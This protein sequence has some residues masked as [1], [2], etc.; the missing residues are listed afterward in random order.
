[1]DRTTVDPVEELLTEPRVYAG[2]ATKEV[3]RWVPGVDPVTG[4]KI[5]VVEHEIYLWS[6]QF[7][8]FILHD[9]LQHKKRARK[10]SER[11]GQL[12]MQPKLRRRNW[13]L[14]E[15]EIRFGI[16]RVEAIDKLC[17]LPAE[18]RYADPPVDRDLIPSA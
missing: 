4:T 9:V 1:M 3:W 13:L 7:A 8:F 2:M 16:R 12:I 10:L 17:W 14:A 5:E 15:D 11:F 6:T 18:G